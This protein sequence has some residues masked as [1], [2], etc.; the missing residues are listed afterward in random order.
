MIALDGE[1]GKGSGRSV[2]AFDLLA[3]LTACSRAPAAASAV[4][5][6]R[7]AWRSS[8]GGVDDFAARWPRTPARPRAEEPPVVE[9]VDA[10]VGGEELGM[11]LAEELQALAP[12]GRGNPPVCLM[13][14][15]ATL[16]GSRGRWE[17][18]S[19][20][21]FTVESQRRARAG[22]RVRARSGGCR[23]QD[24]RAGRCDVRPGGQRVERCQRAATG[25]P[26]GAGRDAVAVGEAEAAE[27]ED[28]PSELEQ[29][30]PLTAA[31]VRP[32]RPLPCMDGRQ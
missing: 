32:G 13:L 31:S 21:R 26:A 4:T 25:A 11:E 28:R 27:V 29:V 5:V 22:G 2:E 20:L 30:A 8:A 7:R 6:R 15:D 3:G 16:H 1:N 19:T 14:A 10:V 17:K 18:A 12:F 23:S 9:R 24:G